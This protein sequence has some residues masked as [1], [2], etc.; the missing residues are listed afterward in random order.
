MPGHVYKHLELT[1]SST[2]SSDDA[3]RVAIAKAA[4][5]VR[6]MNWF[7]VMETRGYIEKDEIAHWQVTIRIGFR[8]D[9]DD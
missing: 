3:I 8:I 6:N 2:V 9:D 1:G 5:S 4:K 7:Q